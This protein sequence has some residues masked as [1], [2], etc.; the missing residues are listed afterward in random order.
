MV[1]LDYLG[2]VAVSVGLNTDSGKEIKAAIT[3]IEYLQKIIK[4][5]FELSRERRW[6]LVQCILELAANAISSKEDKDPAAASG[7]PE[8]CTGCS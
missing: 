5:A 2:R 6:P 8:S 3:E 7:A 4:S 1:D